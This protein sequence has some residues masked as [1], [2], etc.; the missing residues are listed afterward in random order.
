MVLGAGRETKEDDINPA[1][2]LILH[3]KI[4]DYVK[5][6]DVIATVYY[7]GDEKLESSLQLLNDAYKYSAE[8]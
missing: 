7:D 8:K 4:G 6:G 5:K 3:K 1:I 2:G